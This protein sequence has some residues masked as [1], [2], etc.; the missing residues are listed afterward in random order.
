MALTMPD[1]AAATHPESFRTRPAPA[2]AALKVPNSV[3]KQSE[4]ERDAWACRRAI[5]L[6]DL[7]MK[8]VE[9]E[10]DVKAPQLSAWLNADERP[11]IERFKSSARLYA[12]ILMAE[13]EQSGLYEIET[14]VRV[15][16]T[17]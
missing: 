10:L 1:V 3:R 4:W 15:R 5:R 9:Q 12:H 2:K 16:R 14:T 13:L 11:Q 8:D 7:D 6:S 17:A